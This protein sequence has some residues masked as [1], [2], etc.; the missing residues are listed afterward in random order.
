[1]HDYKSYVKE[2]LERHPKDQFFNLKRTED[3][4]TIFH[5]ELIGGADE[6]LNYWCEPP[7]GFCTEDEFILAIYGNRASIVLGCKRDADQYRILIKNPGN[8]P[9]VLRDGGF[10]PNQYYP[11][12]DVPDITRLIN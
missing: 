1:M 2:F 5:G 12:M 6:A 9:K 8:F 11:E 10:E 4:S 3:A 7:I